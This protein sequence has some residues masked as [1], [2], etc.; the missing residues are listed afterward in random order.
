VGVWGDWRTRRR[1][2]A[3]R[4][5]EATRRV[6]RECL[7][8][9]PREEIEAVVVQHFRGQG[10]EVRHWEFGGRLDLEL[11]TD[12]STVLLQLQN[13][14]EIRMG[15]NRVA[16]VHRAGIAFGA[17]R[18]ILVTGGTFTWLAEQLGGKLGVDLL[19]GDALLRIA[20]A[21]K[22]TIGAGAPLRVA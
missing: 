8:S 1:L 11:I 3:E 6:A 18:T 7:L 13:W 9:A 12:G 20:A 14:R 21:Q 4:R 5:S 2:D 22:R 17:V 10:Y 16:A 19:D 15:D